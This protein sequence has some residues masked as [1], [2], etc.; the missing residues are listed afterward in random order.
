MMVSVVVPVYNVAQYVWDCLWSVGQQDYTDIECL[1]IE[2]HST[3]K[4][5]GVVRKFV[6]QYHGNVEFRIISL[7]VNRGLSEAR[8][9]G[10]ENSKGDFIF[11]LDGD[12]ELTS[13]CI[14]SMVRTQK[15]KSADIVVGSH[16]YVRLDGGIIISIAETRGNIFLSSDKYWPAC[17]WNKLLSISYL[18]QHNIRFVP[19]IYHEDVLW[20]YH[21]LSHSPSIAF[22]PNITYVYKER[23]LSIMNK[24][25][26]VTL[27]K[28]FESY[29]SILEMMIKTIPIDHDRRIEALFFIERTARMMS[30][31]MLSV[32]CKNEAYRLFDF[33]CNKVKIPFWCLVSSSDVPIKD[34]LKLLYVYL[35][36]KLSFSI[37]SWFYSPQR[38]GLE[39]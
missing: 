2:D 13:D 25:D 12:D 24:R 37:F 33:A 32:H 16:K 17:A 8:N 5:M 11:F 38:K 22:S 26:D 15:Q 34:R 23:V 10:I 7:P 9:I 36:Q 14:S 4:S 3:D 1:I 6:E 21:L 18:N 28:R 39:K 27:N 29:K 30:C 31:Q 35:P 20:T 19:H